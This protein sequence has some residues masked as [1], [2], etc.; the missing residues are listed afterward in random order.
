[1]ESP[2]DVFRTIWTEARMRGTLTHRNAVCVSTI[3]GNGFPSSRFVDLKE[4][5]DSGFVFCTSLESA[6]ALDLGRD[7]KACITAW[8]EHVATQI[9]IKGLCTVISSREADA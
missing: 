1:M 6:K 5:D 3:D 9:R 2:L 8:W 7:P 4:A